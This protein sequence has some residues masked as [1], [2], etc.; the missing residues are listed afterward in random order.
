MVR[1]RMNPAAWLV[2]FALL[3]PTRASAFLGVDF[4]M[5]DLLLWGEQ[6]ITVAPRLMD[7]CIKYLHL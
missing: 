6:E 2:A 3:L 1:T 4:V 7:L 5:A